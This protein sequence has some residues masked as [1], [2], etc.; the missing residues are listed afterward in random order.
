VRQRWQYGFY[1][2]LIIAA[3]LQAGCTFIYL[4]DLD[5]QQT[6]KSLTMVHPFL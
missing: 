4:K 6:I 2:S 3:A 1:D 5:H